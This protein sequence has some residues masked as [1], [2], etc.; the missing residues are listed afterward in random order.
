VWV[1]L[2]HWVSAPTG[3]LDMFIRQ[4]IGP[5]EPILRGPTARPCEA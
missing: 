3:A 1:K 5:I 2:V 4:T